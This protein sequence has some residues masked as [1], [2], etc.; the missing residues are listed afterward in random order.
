MYDIICKQIWLYESNLIWIFILHS[1]QVFIIGKQA[2]A[3]TVGSSSFNV[4]LHGG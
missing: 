3:C 2:R 4:A 1:I